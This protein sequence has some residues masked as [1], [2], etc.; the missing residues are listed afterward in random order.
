MEPPQRLGSPDGDALSSLTARAIL[1]SFFVALAVQSPLL[2][3]FQAAGIRFSKY[4]LWAPLLTIAAV[5][6]FLAASA[7]RPRGVLQRD[8][9]ITAGVLA[10]CFF[11]AFI[12][13][14]T[15]VPE[16]DD[17]FYVPN[18]VHFLENRH[19][20]M[21]FVIHFFR[22]SDTTPIVSY[23]QGTSLPY[24][25]ARGVVA[26]YLGTDYLFV[27]YLLSAP[28]A[29]F[30]IPLAYFA[31]LVNFTSDTRQALVATVFAVAALLVLTESY[32]SPGSVAFP[33]VY[34]G[35]AVMMSLGLPAFAA[36]SFPF[37]NKPTL[38][39]WIV[40]AATTA[41]VVGMNASATIL[42]STLI[43]CLS[44]A[45]AVANSEAFSESRSRRRIA[46]TIASYI[47]TVSY[48]VLYAGFI[49][50]SVRLEGSAK[51]PFD[52]PFFANTYL[53]SAKLLTS[54]DSLLTPLV[55]G[56]GFCG[57]LWLGDDRLRRTILTWVATLTVVFL[58]PTAF[59]LWG[60]R[61]IPEAVY[62]RLFHVYPVILVAGLAPSLMLRRF[63]RASIAIAAVVLALGSAQY[64]SQFRPRG[65]FGRPIYKM[66]RWWLS[67]ARAIVRVA[68]EGAMLAPPAVQ[69]LVPMLASGRPQISARADATAFWLSAEDQ[70]LRPA[71]A[72]F[73]GGEDA[74]EPKFMRVL[75]S[76]IA[77]VVV[78]SIG[79][80][81]RAYLTKLLAEAG[82][83]ETARSENYLVA[84]RRPPT[85]H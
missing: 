38:R 63:R 85:K 55:A 67:A 60:G 52:I 18:V 75:R 65:T 48:A 74:R 44:A 23:T 32:R 73:A 24:D 49:Y 33:R 3:I 59:D 47:A 8:Y 16:G 1:S 45:H 25:Y 7:R 69:G 5:L 22:G 17:M 83:T 61:L 81:S 64:V 82:Y 76:G 6:W 31:L 15:N 12:A 79:R 39:R 56:I 66:N 26:Y 53:E 40:L 78:V 57:V 10:L 36:L 19:A 35:K 58:N 29:G 27:Y 20:P 41:A 70:K 77:D 28:L 68:P 62:W 50:F 21:D 2:L 34:Q 9:P 46:A 14:C 72:R 37:L 84:W 54:R 42:L 11:C 4:L 13:L 80:R 30:L 43:L 51:D 71:A